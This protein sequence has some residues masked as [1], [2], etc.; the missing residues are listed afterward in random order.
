[1]IRGDR[2]RDI[3][4]PGSPL[5]GPLAFCVAAAALGRPS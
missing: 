1:M 4:L 3:D 2:N 5:A